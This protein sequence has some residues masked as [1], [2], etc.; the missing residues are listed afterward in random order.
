MICKVYLDKYLYIGFFFFLKSSNA[1]IQKTKQKKNLSL[2]LYRSYYEFWH[3]D[4]IWGSLSILWLRVKTCS[5]GKTNKNTRSFAQG[6]WNRLAQ[7]FTRN[8]WNVLEN[9]NDEEKDLVTGKSSYF[10]Y[11]V[12]IIPLSHTL[13]NINKFEDLLLKEDSNFSSMAVI[14]CT[15]S[16]LTA[17]ATLLGSK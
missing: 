10:S 1:K 14:I 3:T 16:C 13:A 2:P 11:A 5:Q 17:W 4:V 15:L 7:C 12:P 9:V 8:D 6:N